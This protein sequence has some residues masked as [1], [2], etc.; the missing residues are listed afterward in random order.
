MGALLC[1]TCAGVLIE[2]GRECRAVTVFS[3]PTA[4]VLK[5]DRFIPQQ[6]GCLRGKVVIKMVYISAARCI[7]NLGGTDQLSVPNH[8]VG[9]G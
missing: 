7:D 6:L 1:E 9:F 8:N 4:V 5:H 3:A 2:P